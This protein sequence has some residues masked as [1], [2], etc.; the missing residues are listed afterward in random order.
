LSTTSAIIKKH[1]N[2]KGFLNTTVT[3]T[4]RKD[5]GDANSVILDVKI[6]KKQ[7]LK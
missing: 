4:Q 2:E 3:M 5:P 7:K 6:D 1:F